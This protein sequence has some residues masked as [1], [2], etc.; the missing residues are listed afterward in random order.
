MSFADMEM[1][2]TFEDLLDREKLPQ[3]LELKYHNVRDA[4]EQ[5]GSVQSIG[6]V[7]IGFLAISVWSQFGSLNYSLYIVG[8]LS[9]N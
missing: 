3:L 1:A 6:E 4:V 2:L 7:F 5:L 8:K 9:W